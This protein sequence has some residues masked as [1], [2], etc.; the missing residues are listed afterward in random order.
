VLKAK[1]LIIVK[2]CPQVEILL[3]F[4]GAYSQ[5]KAVFNNVVITH[6]KVK[7]KNYLARQIPWK[8][9]IGAIFAVLALAVFTSGCKITITSSI[10]FVC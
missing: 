9:Y 3:S 2:I 1:L 10:M 4:N 6:C 7:F 8:N 5:T